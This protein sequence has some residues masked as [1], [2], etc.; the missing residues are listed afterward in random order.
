M[1]DARVDTESV[2]VGQ[3]PVGLG[4]CSISTVSA[5]W[6]AR[7]ATLALGMGRRPSSP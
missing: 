2:E 3:G 7:L 1:L 4:E 6:P 5:L